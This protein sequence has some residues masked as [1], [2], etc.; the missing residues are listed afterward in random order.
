MV[1]LRVFRLSL[2]VYTCVW[3]C[4]NKLTWVTGRLTVLST[5]SPWLLIWSYWPP[6]LM[7]FSSLAPCGCIY[8]SAELLYSLNPLALH[9]C[10][11][12]CHALPC[13]YWLWS[14]LHSRPAGGGTS[15]PGR[16]WKGQRE[17]LSGR[18]GEW[19]DPA[20][21]EYSGAMIMTS[22][23]WT[24]DACCLLLDHVTSRLKH[25]EYMYPDWILKH[26]RIETTDVIGSYVTNVIRKQLK[27][28]VYTS[29]LHCIA[30]SPVDSG[31]VC[32]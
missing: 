13:R 1:M 6:R 10:W 23:R 28:A 5:L 16:G 8:R 12:L 29:G 26:N 3:H 21:R 19:T 31:L 11:W 32:K 14:P 24:A 30:V 4:V 15:A 9:R 2:I 18:G 17:R 20:R 7:D 25:S 27:S 22:R